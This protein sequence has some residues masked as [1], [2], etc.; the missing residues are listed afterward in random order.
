MTVCN[1]KSDP[2]YKLPQCRFSPYPSPCS[3]RLVIS[4]STF[5]HHAPVSFVHSI[6][7]Q[8]E[9]AIKRMIEASQR[10]SRIDREREKEKSPVNRHFEIKIETLLSAPPRDAEISRKTS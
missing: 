7:D 5:R 8:T 2:Y 3:A 9:V 6:H 10:M 4:V 1:L